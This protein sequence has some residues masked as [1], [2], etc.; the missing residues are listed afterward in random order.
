MVYLILF[1]LIAIAAWVALNLR[2]RAATSTRTP[3]LREVYLDLESSVE[4]AYAACSRALAEATASVHEADSERGMLRADL[5]VDGRGGSLALEIQV[6]A[7]EDGAGSDVVIGYHT[8]AHTTEQRRAAEVRLRELSARIRTLTEPPDDFWE[9]SGLAS[10]DG[11]KP[12]P[13]E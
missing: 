2:Q 13:L 6:R 9:T 1:G 12:E 4:D 11:L 3:K 7:D 8:V 10:I 5:R